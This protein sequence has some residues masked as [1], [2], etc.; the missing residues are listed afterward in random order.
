MPDGV[1]E[2]L[3]NL[4][5][6]HQTHAEKQMQVAANDA[7]ELLA[8]HLRLLLV[9]RIERARVVRNRQLD[10]VVID[11]LRHVATIRYV[12]REV[13]FWGVGRKVVE[14]ILIVG[15]RPVD[16]CLR[17]LERAAGPAHVLEKVP[18][19][20][21]LRRLVDALERVVALVEAG[22][23]VVDV[24]RVAAATLDRDHLRADEQAGASRVPRVGVDHLVEQAPIGQIHDKR[25]VIENGALTVRPRV[26]VIGGS[27]ESDVSG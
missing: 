19:A 8:V 5:K 23:L 22:L 9:A 15:A 7:Q 11:I 6:A 1:H 17:A 18:R 24:E 14:R 3:T 20:V 26:G 16:A 27:P 10:N 21:H 2:Q 25:V 12:S 4:H 13:E